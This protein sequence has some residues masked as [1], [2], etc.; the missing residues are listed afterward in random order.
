MEPANA[1]LWC[2]IV[3][4]LSEI[5]M[6]VGES[7][8]LEPLVNAK[9]RSIAKKVLFLLQITNGRLRVAQGIG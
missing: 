4:S 7:S 3:L 8:P 2:I 9:G 1:L 5:T 6:G